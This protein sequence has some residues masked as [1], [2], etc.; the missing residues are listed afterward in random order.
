MSASGDTTGAGRTGGPF[1]WLRA[2]L[3]N[4]ADSE[5]EMSFNRL[6][7]ALLILIY[8]SA[9]EPATMGR[10]LFAVALWLVRSQQTVDDVSYMRAMIPHHSIAVLTSKRAQIS[11]PRV[12]KLA[13]Q[14]IASQQREIVEMKSLIADIEANGEQTE[15]QTTLNESAL[16]PDV[17]PPD[18]S[19]E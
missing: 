11:D 3:R 18:P 1:A 10:I 19:S 5:H 16:G 8:V 6:F 9:V 2:R 15:S 13:D 14:I 7:F 12:R 17:P 4:R